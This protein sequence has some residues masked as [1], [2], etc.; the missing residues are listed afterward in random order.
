VVPLVAAIGDHGLDAMN[1]Q[2]AADTRGAVAA[3]PQQPFRPAVAIPAL[4]Q[5]FQ[6]ARFVT[7]A[8]AEQHS[9]RKAVGRQSANGS[10]SPNRRGSVRALSRSPLFRPR[11]GAAGT[12]VAPVNAPCV[13]INPAQLVELQLQPVKQPLQCTVLLPAAKSVIDRFPRTV[14]LGKIAPA[15]SPVQPPE[16]SVQQLT[17]RPPLG[18]A[19]TVGWKHIDKQSPLLIT[20][21]MSA[22][23]HLPPSR[24]SPNQLLCLFPSLE[25]C[26]T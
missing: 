3:V 5:I 26:L 16:H 11:C 21:L 2:P 24:S 19:P 17:M 20:Q 10:S 12:N 15:G 7:L 9:Q 18:A 14:T 4:D 1:S 6:I 23:S 25:K 13:P 22:Y 8:R